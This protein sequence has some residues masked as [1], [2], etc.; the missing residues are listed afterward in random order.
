MLKKFTDLSVHSSG[1]RDK[2]TKVNIN[3][4]ICPILLFIETL[5][6][7]KLENSRGAFVLEKNKDVNNDWEIGG[8]KLDLDILTHL[9]HQLF[10]IIATMLYTS[11]IHIIID[12]K[13]H[14]V[15]CKRKD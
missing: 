1:C 15:G 10:D 8:E 7:I 2:E 5:H 4:E 13:L 9:N 14:C 11:T 6:E 12:P 3:N